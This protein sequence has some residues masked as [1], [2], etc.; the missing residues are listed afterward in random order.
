MTPILTSPLQKGKK[1]PFALFVILQLSF[2]AARASNEVVSAV[3]SGG[4]QSPT[5]LGNQTPCTSIGF[6]LISYTIPAGYTSLQSIQWWVNNGISNTLVRTTTGAPSTSLVVTANTFIVYCVAVYSNGSQTTTGTSNNY[7]VNVK[8]IFLNS[9]TGPAAIAL[10]CP[11]PVTFTTSL[12]SSQFVYTPPS[13]SYTVSWELPSTWGF[14][15]PNTGLSIAAVPDASSGGNV[16][17]IL[18]LNSCPF[19]TTMSDA[20]TRNAPAPTFGTNPT[21]VCNNSV[22]TFSINPSCGATSYNYTLSGNTGATFQAN[23]T[24]SLS[25]TATSVA[26][27]AGTVNSTGVTLSAEAV[28]PGGVTSTVA[29]DNIV[30]GT[31]GPIVTKIV[32]GEKLTGSGP[33]TYSMTT[34][35]SEPITAYKW[36]VSP[37]ATIS[38][39][40][41]GTVTFTTPSLNAGQSGDVYI[42]AEYE[43]ACGGWVTS[44]TY[45]FVDEGSGKG[46]L[47]LQPIA[48]MSQIGIISSGLENTS[49]SDNNPYAL[50]SPTYTIK[51]I[52]VYNT[53]GQLMKKASFG[54]TNTTEYLD[55]HDLQNGIYFV[56]VVTSNGSTTKKF[57]VMR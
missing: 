48:G 13:G 5:E 2:S 17:A 35:I 57:V 26:I 9:I 36:I 18:A 41:T 21:P 25:T 43:T 38:G 32:D 54:G 44:P 23:G 53:A 29:T 12:A 24:Q 28:Y 34:T 47:T 14:S 15:G 55:I 19:Q 51:A 22:N 56:Q 37:T 16:E 11:S 33:F 39:Q 10:G 6:S 3:T 4:P 46:G 42:T 27:S 1:I 8:G 30:T 40:T 45:Y 52:N 50:K 31:P 20:V 7:Q 49:V